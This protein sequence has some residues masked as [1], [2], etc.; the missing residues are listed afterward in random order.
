MLQALRVT[1]NRKKN[2]VTVR[3]EVMRIKRESK[4]TIRQMERGGKHKE[5]L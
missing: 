1:I 5:N 2:E 3:E 4:E